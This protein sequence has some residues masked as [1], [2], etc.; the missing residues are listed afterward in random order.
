MTRR[1]LRGA[2][3]AAALLAAALA[4]GGVAAR[5]H[6]TADLLRR[7]EAALAAREY[8][9]A[10]DHLERYLAIRP[11]DA[12]ARLLAA[13]AARRL[14]EYDRA[15]E[16]LRR[17]RQD[18]G[19]AAAVEIEHALIDLQQGDASRVEALRLR[20]RADDELALVVLE[21]VIQ[22]DLDTYRL[23]LAQD[24]LN[25]YLARRPDD[26]HALLGRGYLWEKLLSF[27]DALADYRRAAA[28]HPDSERARERLAATLLI[29][30]TPGEALEQYQWLAARWPDRADVRLGLARCRRRLGQYDEAGALLDGLLADA[31]EDGHV[32]WERGQVELDQGRPADAEEWLRKALRHIPHDRKVTHSLYR[33]LLELGRAEEAGAFDA[34]TAQLDADLKRLDEVCREVMRRPDDA[35][36]RCEGG[37]LFLRNGE[38]REGVRWLQMALKLDPGC[39]KARAALAEAESRP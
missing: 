14:R 36:L 22:Y 28:A 9:Q 6:W 23:R 39:E 11:D 21:A 17:C 12:R 1:T 19:D 20:S 38:R 3:V 35:A 37:L 16:H 30:G 27:A 7:G 15:R 5:R 24:G 32:L 31:P 8:G 29:A 10:K 26:L 33:C 2:L 4:V 18:G 25:R 13:R 34:R